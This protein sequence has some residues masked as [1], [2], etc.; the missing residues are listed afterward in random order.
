MDKTEEIRAVEVV[1][2]IRDQQARQLEGK[3]EAEIV[4]FF[5]RAGDEARRRAGTREQRAT[6]VP[7]GTGTG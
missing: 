2:R 4:E 6:S 3:P 1:R 7:N 5:N